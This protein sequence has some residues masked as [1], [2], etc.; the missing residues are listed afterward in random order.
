MLPLFCGWFFIIFISSL[1]QVG[2]FKQVVKK[3]NHNDLSNKKGLSLRCDGWIQSW[4]KTISFSHRVNVELFSCLHS[5][6]QD[7]DQQFQMAHLGDNSEQRTVY[8][9]LS[10]V[11]GRVVKKVEANSTFTYC[12]WLIF[13]WWRVHVIFYSSPNFNTFLRIYFLTYSLPIWGGVVHGVPR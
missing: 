2:S 10:L 9:C 7:S 4:L 5:W 6:S 8:S 13:F 1:H 3:W 11:L 12:V